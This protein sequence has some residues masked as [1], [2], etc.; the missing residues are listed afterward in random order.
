MKKLIRQIKNLLK[1][2]KELVVFAVVIKVRYLLSKRLK[3]KI[4][5]KKEAVEI[6]VVHLCQI[7]HGLI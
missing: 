7:K 5:I 6:I 1:L 4:L 2:S 3:A